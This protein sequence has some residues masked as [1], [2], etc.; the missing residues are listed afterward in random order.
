MLAVQCFQVLWPVCRMAII[1]PMAHVENEE[2]W[3][4]QFASGTEGGLRDRKAGRR[5]EILLEKPSLWVSFPEPLQHFGVCKM[6]R[7][8]QAQK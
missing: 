2:F 7:V 6:S 4:L 3:F 5:P 1:E 8:A